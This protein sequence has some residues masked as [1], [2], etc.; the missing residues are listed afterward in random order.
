MREMTERMMGDKYIP[1]VNSLSL[2]CLVLTHA[3][4]PLCRRAAYDPR[5]ATGQRQPEVEDQSAGRGTQ[6]GCRDN[7]E[8]L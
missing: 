1:L 4:P 6:K 5:A 3:L 7:P 8:A 2:S